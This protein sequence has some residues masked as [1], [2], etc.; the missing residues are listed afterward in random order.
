MALGKRVQRVALTAL[1]ALL[2]V[3]PAAQAQPQSTRSLCGFA[4]VDPWY[5]GGVTAIYTHCADSFILIRVDRTGQNAYNRCVAPWGKV[6]FRPAEN[7]VNAYYI[8]VRPHVAHLDDRSL[9]S[10]DQ[11][12]G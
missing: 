7:V 8:P 12:T 10:K 3:A 11:P 9:C 6:P 1:T 4:K 5:N 2:V